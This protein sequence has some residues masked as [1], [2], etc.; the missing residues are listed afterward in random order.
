MKR[1]EGFLFALLLLASSGRTQTIDSQTAND[2][3]ENDL[4]KQVT[5]ARS[6]YTQADAVSAGV[7]LNAVDPKETTLWLSFRVG[8]R[9]RWHDRP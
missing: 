1:K 3:P 7:A 6:A 5:L 9:A 8:C 2:L 4:P